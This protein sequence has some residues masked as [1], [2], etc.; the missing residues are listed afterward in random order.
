MLES[1]MNWFRTATP[2]PTFNGQNVQIGVHFEEVA[3]M[4]DTLEGT[5][6][7]TDTLIAEAADALRNLSLA[8]KQG[9]AHGSVRDPVE[10]ADAMADQVVT[11]MGCCHQTHIDGPLA[12]K[13]ANE[14][15]YSKFEDGHAVFDAHG[16]ITKGANY[17]RADFSKALV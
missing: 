15:N 14:S 10:F 5:T 6:A 3:E 17:K 1:I 11:A 2:T 13:L 12:V 4:L 7:D 8:L 9:R 16:K